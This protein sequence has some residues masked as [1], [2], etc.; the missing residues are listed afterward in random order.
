MR[1]VTV[2]INV[3]QQLSPHILVVPILVVPI[4]IAYP[5]LTN[6]FRA[7]FGV[8][9]VLIKDFCLLDKLRLFPRQQ[10]LGHGELQTVNE[11][12]LFCYTFH[13]DNGIFLASL[14]SDAQFK[15]L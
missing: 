3:L 1:C 12:A 14:A 11:R 9:S 5:P 7:D 4:A 8:L 13:W 2:A 6:Y 15:L 10:A